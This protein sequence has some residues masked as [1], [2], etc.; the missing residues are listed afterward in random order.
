[1]ERK[2][3]RNRRLADYIYNDLN[4]EKVV[5]LEKEISN[6]PQ[7]SESYQLNM[8]V[9]NYLQSKIQLEE[10]R[11]DPQLEDAEKL[12]D[13]AFGIE[14]HDEA[15][16]DPIP[17]SPKRNR[18]RYLSLVAAVAASVTI[19]IAVGIFPSSMDQDRLFDRYYEPYGASDNSQRGG[20]NEFRR[21]VAAGINSYVEGNYSQ[22]IAQFNTL[23]SDP[24]IRSEVQYF[25]A[26]SYLGLGQFESSQ[27]HFEVLLE[28]DNKYELE[29]LWYLSLCY[30]KTGEL[31]K[32]QAILG[33]VENYEGIYK[34][35]AQ[36]LGKKFRR[37]K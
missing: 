2:L 24:S 11:S 8:Q 3:D 34:K 18:V 16:S 32:A 12:A 33:Q 21:D 5:E 31:E 28:G 9:K 20:A 6:D 25:T 30:L 14:S 17:E 1:M 23:A 29:T 22:S 15:A 36:A 27:A 13:M 26:L 37:R 7:L 19:L 4:S 35:D 10:M